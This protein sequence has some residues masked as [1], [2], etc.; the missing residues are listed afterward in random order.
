MSESIK[1]GHHTSQV[2]K[3]ILIFKSFHDFTC[4]MKINRR[5]F[6][7]PHSWK[8]V[9]IILDILLFKNTDACT[10]PVLNFLYVSF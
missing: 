6:I 8:Y 9:S 3:K 2:H 7:D 4:L 5:A 1:I 10:E